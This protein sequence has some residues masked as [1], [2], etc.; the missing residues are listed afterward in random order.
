[1]AHDAVAGGNAYL[2]ASCCCREGQGRGAVLGDGI[3]S[4]IVGIYVLLLPCGGYFSNGL[5]VKSLPVGR[6]AN[7]EAQGCPCTDSGRAGEGAEIG[8]VNGVHVYVGSFVSRIEV[9][10]LDFGRSF[11]F[12]S[13][14]VHRAIKADTCTAGGCHAAG[15]KL[16]NK[17]MG[18]RA[19]HHDA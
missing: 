19:V 13:I 11:P 16:G 1:M 3:H 4:E 18:G 6:Y 2:A 9:G 8:I 10:I 7:G 12:D 17:G 15:R 5:A 14:E